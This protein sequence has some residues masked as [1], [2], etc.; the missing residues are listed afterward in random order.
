MIWG[1][2][3]LL[4]LVMFAGMAQAATVWGGNPAAS[5]LLLSAGLFALVVGMALTADALREYEQGDLSDLPVAA[6]TLIYQ[7]AA[8]GENSSGYMRGLVAGDPFRGFALSQADNSATATNGYITV[9]VRQRGRIQLLITSLSITDIDK[10]VYASADGTFVLTPEGNTW[11]GTVIRYV[12]SGVGIVEFN[13]TAQPIEPFSVSAPLLVGKKHHGIAAASAT[14]CYPL[15]TIMRK[16][17]GREFVYAKAGGTLNTDMGAKSANT[18]HVAY[19]ALGASSASG[20]S[21]ITVT[22]GG[23][24]GA[25]TNGA[26][27]ANELAGGYV[28]VFPHSSN[29][30][31]RRILAN[32]V[33]AGGGGT[34]VLT[35]D[36][37]IPVAVEVTNDHAEV[38]ASPFYNVQSLT[39]D[40]MSVVGIPTVAATVGQFLWLLK[41]GIGW[42]APQT[43]VSVGSNN[44]EVVFRH[45]GSIDEHKY[46]DATVAK[47]QHAGYVVQNAAGG[48]QGAPFV[49][50][51]I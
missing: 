8:V 10:A 33:V 9:N 47:G 20:A 29:T 3:I 48:G 14:Q 13:A 23:S 41:K 25:A 49:H 34:C 21:T 5:T 19:A 35:L 6:S 45:D 2:L 32:A 40:T 36:D 18:Q 51:D 22:V 42:V 31:V 15:G 24:D 16:V 39:T 7:G 4:A 28:T 11:I 43:G 38:M 37:P 1:A 17:D 27:A 26:I 12:S 44:R 50:F 46:N 30:F